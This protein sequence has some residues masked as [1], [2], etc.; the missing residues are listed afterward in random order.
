[1]KAAPLALVVAA[2]LASGGC[3]ARVEVL[4]FRA[5]Q[6]CPVVARPLSPAAVAEEDANVH[7]FV[8]NQ[9]FEDPVVRVALS[10]DGVP[11]V[12]QDFDVCGQHDW[13]AFPLRLQPG[14]HDVVVTSPT[15]IRAEHRLEVPEPP[16]ERWVVVSHWV[17]PTPR[18]DVEVRSEQVGFA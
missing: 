18:F 6:E 16:G 10:V 5:G 14:W 17:D 13:V 12:D 8:S 9:A 7:L 11:T 4:G 1:M 15:G 2:A 3:G